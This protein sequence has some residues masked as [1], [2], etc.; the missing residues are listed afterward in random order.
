MTCEQL[1]Q[2]HGTPS[3]STLKDDS[4][5]PI[6]DLVENFDLRIRNQPTAGRRGILTAHTTPATDPQRSPQRGKSS[7]TPPNR[8]QRN[9]NSRHHQ[10]L[11][12]G[13]SSIDAHA[14]VYQQ[15]QRQPTYL[16]WP[17]GVVTRRMREVLETDRTEGIRTDGPDTSVIPRLMEVFIDNNSRDEACETDAAGLPNLSHTRRTTVSQFTLSLGKAIHRDDVAHGSC[18][19]GEERKEKKNGGGRLK[20][21][22]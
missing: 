16:A 15:Q 21:T 9:T 17:L 13:T 3:V 11:T 10:A 20:R 2:R 7:H 6:P 14:C 18:T 5:C 22:P 1:L 8:K 12:E 4:E 19:R